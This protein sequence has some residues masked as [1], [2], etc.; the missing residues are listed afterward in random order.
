MS[1]AWT[2][3]ALP[4]WPAMVVVGDAVSQEAAAEILIRTQSFYFSTNAHSFERELYMAVGIQNRPDVDWISPDLDSLDAAVAKYGCLDLEYLLNERIVSA[5]IC[6]PHGWC[7]W[8]G[9]IGC[10]DYN[11]GK[12]PTCEAVLAEWE[13]IAEAFPFLDLTCQLFSDEGCVEGVSPVVEYRIKDGK[14]KIGPPRG[15]LRRPENDTVSAVAK[16]VALPT[17]QREAG[18]TIAQFKWAL[19]TTLRRWQNR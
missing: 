18:C 2:A 12:W 14:A 10:H 11:I 8:A 1:K 15:V 9:N 3:P 4:K 7:S 19:E 16:L 17:E 6:G 5:W 13:R